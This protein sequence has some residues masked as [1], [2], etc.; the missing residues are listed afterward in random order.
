MN[1][2]EKSKDAMEAA[3]N[4][5]NRQR[6][7]TVT[8]ENLR[9][10]HGAWILAG[11]F[12]LMLQSACG[13]SGMSDA[14]AQGSNV[15]SSGAQDIGVFRSILEAG[16]IPGPDTLDANGF[17]AEHVIDLPPPDC[18]Q[19]ICLQTSLAMANDWVDGSYQRIV[20]IALN[21]P[22]DPSGMER[23]PMDL[24]VVVDR[25]GSMGSQGKMTYVLEGLHSLVDELQPGDRMGLVSYSSNVEVLV[26]LDSNADA[27]TLD[28]A[29]DRMYPAGSTNLYEGLQTGLEMAANAHDPQRQSRVILM[30]DGL[31]TAGIVDADQIL[32]M[33]DAFVADG[34][35]LTTIG[36]GLDFDV[37]LMRS[38]AERG[39]GNFYFLDDPSAIDE[40]F[41]EELDTFMV[42]IAQDLTI[43]V[44]TASGYRIASVTGATFWEAQ[45]YG[46]S[47]WLP[48][49]FLAARTTSTPHEEGRRGGGSKFYLELEPT[50]QTGKNSDMV[51]VHLSY[52]GAADREIHEQVVRLSDP[53][54]TET[55]DPYYEWTG[56]EK[57]TAV[58]LLYKGLHRACEEAQW[59]YDK[60]LGLLMT[61]RSQAEEWQYTA[62]DADM[63]D[64]LALVDQFI[65]NL[66]ARGAYPDYDYGETMYCGTDTATMCSTAP[67]QASWYWLAWL[68]LAWTGI[69]LRRRP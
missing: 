67:A 66:Q 54:G 4:R 55:T 34:V 17:F 59:S 69:K 40:V 45:N 63:A 46:G 21:S 20:Q 33:S 56:M 18:G 61:L 42:P 32:Q 47:L 22:I 39:S 19:D 14:G 8:S 6:Q 27:T 9:W 30:S 62:E 44:R 38:L 37:N 12:G 13:A 53:N 51:E 43:E 48:S 3:M 2:Q 23:P 58:F 41:T 5:H 15:G 29:I 24:V 1:V 28:Q 52:R 36:V 35:G 60:A 57:A 26:D 11:F 64:D 50:G 16:Q 65:A 25:S 31:P 10:M 7:Q 49:V 68:G